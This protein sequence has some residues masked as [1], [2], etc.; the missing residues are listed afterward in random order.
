[1]K[2]LISILVI[3]VTISCI[4]QQVYSQ[5][6]DWVV[7]KFDSLSDIGALVELEM[8][9]DGVYIR[10]ERVASKENIGR[11]DQGDV[12][13]GF[14]PESSSVWVVKHEGN[15]GYI[16]DS[17]VAQS[18][19]VLKLKATVNAEKIREKEMER[20]TRE[21][22]AEEERK[23]EQYEKMVLEKRRADYIALK[24]AAGVYAVLEFVKTREPNSA[25]GVDVVLRVDFVNTKT[26]KYAN[27]FIEPYN[28]VGDKVIDVTPGQVLSELS[29]TG[30]IAPEYGQTSV[31]WETVWYNKTITCAEVRRVELEYI[32]GTK[33]IYVNDLPKILGAR[34]END[35]SY[36]AQN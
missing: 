2:K 11:L 9:I 8:V 7:S 21:R 35:C 29:L 23:R 33:D 32:D 6:I 15:L 31:S 34:F 5:N 16:S 17:Y 20:L 22:E 18:E 30:P 19:P 36:E 28:P 12:I 27:F 14:L 24:Q 10:K 13:K 1:M 25:D 4:H 26:I 3:A